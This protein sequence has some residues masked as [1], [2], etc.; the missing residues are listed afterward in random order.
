MF[1]A[2]L[3]VPT[4]DGPRIASVSMANTNDI[5]KAA[6]WRLPRALGG[7]ENP[8]ADQLDLLQKAKDGIELAQLAAKRW[9]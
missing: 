3:L 7:L 9:R 6:R 1:P 5:A 8:T 4:D 2:I